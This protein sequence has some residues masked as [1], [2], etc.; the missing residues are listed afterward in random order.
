MH[1][2]HLLKAYYPTKVVL[3]GTYELFSYYSVNGQID[4]RGRP[5]H[6]PRYRSYEKGDIEAFQ[7]PYMLFNATY[8]LNLLQ[9]LLDNWKFCYERSVGCVGILKDWMY[10]AFDACLREGKEHLDF[11]FI[12]EFALSVSQCENI[13]EEVRNHENDERL[14]NPTFE[15]KVYA[16]MIWSAKPLP[17]KEQNDNID[18]SKNNNRNS[19]P[20]QRNPVRDKVGY[21]QTDEGVI[22]TN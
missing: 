3:L 8:L 14:F 2:K 4:R 5:L 21:D 22:Q 11:D 20:G 12:R 1:G 7:G 19:S 6:L 15:S 17:P 13:L 9:N 16:S 18:N 10:D